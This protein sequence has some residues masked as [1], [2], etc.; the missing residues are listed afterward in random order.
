[1]EALFNQIPCGLIVTDQHWEVIDCNQ[2]LLQKLQINL[3]AFVGNNIETIFTP[4][5]KLLCQSIIFPQL[6]HSASIE[7]IQLNLTVPDQ[8]PLPVVINARY[9][10]ETTGLVYWVIFP[11]TE[12]DQLHQ[13]LLD[14]G[15]RLEAAN[16]QLQKLAI[17]DE[18]TGLINRR[19]MES[20]LA[21]HLLQVKRRQ[22]CLSVLMLD[23]DHFKPINDEFGHGHGDEVLQQLGQLLTDSLRDGD[24]ASRHGGEEFVLV[25]PDTDTEA[26]IHLATRTHD[27]FKKI[28]CL[29][30]RVTA[31]IGV[32]TM[33]WQG[34]L[35]VQDI[36]KRADDAMYEAKHAGRNR[37]CV[38]Q[39]D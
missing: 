36:L 1:M 11:A 27:L 6:S 18:L 8:Q 35:S 9:E 12:R 26:A 20:R 3:D 29:A 15:S 13:K 25:L 37:T 32:C 39:A 28:D 23:I 33:D 2:Y 22:G 38:Y 30:G 14:S 16:E 10:L 17:T 24:L 21:S 34:L 4:G 5:S 19:E 7:E 31:S